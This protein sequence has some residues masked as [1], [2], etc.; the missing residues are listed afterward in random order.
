MTPE[1]AAAASFSLDLRGDESTG[2]SLAWKLAMRARLGQAGKVSDLLRL[3]FRN[4]ELDRG[5]WVGG[6]YPNLFAAHPPFQID[7]NFGFVSG[8]AECLVQ[9]HDGT[10]ELLKAVPRELA[11]GSVRGLVARPGIEIAIDW[12]PSE[13][14][15]PKLVVATLR[16]LVP[17]AAG[18]HL[19]RY[20]GRELLVRAGTDSAC[21]IKAADFK[22][23]SRPDT[24][25]DNKSAAKIR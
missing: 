25:A 4:M 17:S 20:A 3:V 21:I 19:V 15:D 11:S 18:E 13:G 7:G 8:L 10:I 1:L 6:L 23:V 9:S 16:A 14:G 12:A 5:P 2:W 22:V 24:V